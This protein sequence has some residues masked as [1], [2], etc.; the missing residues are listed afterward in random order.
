MTQES[1]KLPVRSET[2][3][4]IDSQSGNS[5]TPIGRLS[6]EFDRLFDQLGAGMFR[7]PQA[8]QSLLRGVLDRNWDRGVGPATDMAEHDNGY[9]I[10]AELPGIEANDIEV[11]LSNGMLTVRGMKKRE[12]ETNNADYHIS[13]R[14]YGAFTRSFPLPDGIE[15]ERVDARFAK[16]VLTITLPKTA[17]AKQADRK[18]QIRTQ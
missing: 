6:E 12:I 2:R 9:E 13:E 17:A 8:L 10:T 5:F 14:H 11:K 1:T 15:S 3:N 18:V 16:G 4:E 7:G